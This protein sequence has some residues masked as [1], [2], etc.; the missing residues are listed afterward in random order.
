MVGNKATHREG[1]RSVAFERRLHHSSES[2]F[3]QSQ[4]VLNEWMTIFISGCTEI[5]RRINHESVD[6]FR[7]VAQRKAHRGAV[8]VPQN[9]IKT[10][11]R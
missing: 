9:V 3:G 11:K 5:H 8:P 7:V 4:R 6:Q 1:H 10:K 2:I